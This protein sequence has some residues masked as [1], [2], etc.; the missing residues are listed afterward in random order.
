MAVNL[1]NRNHEDSTEMVELFTLND[2]T[3]SIPKKP[4]ANIALRYL[5]E[6]RTLGEDVA[7][8]NLLEAVLGE[9]G[10]TALMDYEDLTMKDLQSIML[11]AQKVVMGGIEDAA[12]ND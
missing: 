2:Q 7:A 11:I 8:G 5:R 12:G 9:E 3:Y 1:D 4:K 10:Y 6:A